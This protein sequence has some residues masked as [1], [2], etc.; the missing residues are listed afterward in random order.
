M[1]K[2]IA[3]IKSIINNK[4]TN[5]KSLIYKEEINPELIF[6]NNALILLNFNLDYLKSLIQ[7]ILN[8]PKKKLKVINARF[9]NLLIALII[10]L[11][12]TLSFLKT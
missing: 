9:Y 6:F 8:C 1:K 3:Q 12:N 4:K 10:T 11:K 5:F 7:I 2:K